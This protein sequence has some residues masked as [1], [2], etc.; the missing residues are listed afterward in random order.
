M[1]RLSLRRLLIPAAVAA[2]GLLAASSLTGV[3]PS[4]S[5]ADPVPA[6][7]V[8]FD[9]SHV[10]A[11]V[12][13]VASPGV[14]NR[15][16]VTEIGN[17][18]VEITDTAGPLVI[19]L[20]CSRVNANTARCYM[21]AK[22]RVY[23]GDGNDRVDA[24]I[25][26][27]TSLYGGPGNDTLNGGHREDYLWGGPGAD[28]LNGGAGQDDLRGE[29]GN[30]VLNGGT[31]DDYVNGHAGDDDLIGDLGNDKLDG[32]TGRDRVDGS[33][34]IDEISYWRHSAGVT[35]TLDGAANDGMAGENDNVLATV[36]DIAGSRYDDRLHGNALPNKL[37]GQPGN[38]RLY[39]YDGNDTLDATD[40]PGHL[41]GGAGIAD[42]CRPTLA[43]VTKVGCELP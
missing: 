27:L 12:W 13:F 10:P 35:V 3:L 8:L 19:D 39:G 4:A 40:G 32:G 17:Q 15:V 1:P 41:D 31:G 34:G 14:T 36:E 28:T 2:C 6:G 29:D 26:V 21:T 37:T 9:N 22:V 25:N 24:P 20:G 7:T 33:A 18:S 38:D 5:A 42:A 30:D 11:D 43:T 23:L 16:T